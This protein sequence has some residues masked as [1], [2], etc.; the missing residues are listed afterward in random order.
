MFYCCKW[1]FFILVNC[2]NVLNKCKMVEYIDILF[3]FRSCF[4]VEKGKYVGGMV[5]F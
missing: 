2:M 4:E 5:G 3:I 1:F